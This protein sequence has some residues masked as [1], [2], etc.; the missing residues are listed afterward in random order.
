M[1]MIEILFAENAKGK[2]AGESEISISELSDEIKGFVLAGT[3]TT[4]NTLTA[5]FLFIYETPGVLE[6][7]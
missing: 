1:N 2:E 5:M 4:A 7:L 6:T 3:D